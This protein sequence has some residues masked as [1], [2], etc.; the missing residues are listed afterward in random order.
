[1]RLHNRVRLGAVALATIAATS[2]AACST[3]SDR[4]SS[5]T[6]SGGG[7]QKIS[8]P[9]DLKIAYFSAGTSNAYLQAAIS[10]AKST[11]GQMGAHL[12]VFDGQFSAQT[13]FNQ[14]QTALTSGKYNAF[15]VEP[16]DGNLVCNLLTKQAAAKGILV[17]VFNE[18]ICGRATNAGDQLWEPGTLTYVGGQTV[19]SYQQWVQQVIADN[20]GGGEVA[21]ITGPDLNANTIVMRE[22]E[23]AL[24]ANPKFNVVAEQTTDYTTPKGFAASQTILQAHPTLKIIMSN[25]SGLTRGVVQAVDG[26]SRKGSV[27]IYDFGGDTWALNAMKSGDLRQTVM[28]LPKQETIDALQALADK[29]QGKQVPKFID[30]TKS[31]TLPGT[32]FVSAGNLSKF[33]A[34]Y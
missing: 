27:R 16:N 20:P 23:K 32:A 7:G 24:K 12:D 29:V 28:M 10:A 26:A 22:A 14:M 2:L 11:A 5:G 25:Y 31:P 34:E 21:V 13:Q 6:S 33:T 3:A 19:G 17:S 30:L 4:A 9:A 15:V 8:S 18:P 1:M